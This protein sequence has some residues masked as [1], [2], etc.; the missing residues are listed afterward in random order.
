MK[1][2]K[3]YKTIQRCGYTFTVEILKNGKPGKIEKD[4]ML[5]APII[6]KAQAGAEL[7]TAE[8]LTLIR[9][10]N[11]SYHDSGKI[12]G[13]FSLDSTATNCSFCEKMRELAKINP[14]MVCAHCYDKEQESYRSSVLNRHTL[15]M[16]IMATVEF[17]V[18]ELALIPVYGLVRINSSGDAPNDIYAAN[19]VKFAIAH[20]DCRVS[21]WTKNALAYIRAC[22][23]YGKPG[24]MILIFSSYCVNKAMRLP[25]YFDYVFTVYSDADA[26]AAALAGGAC[27]CNGK[28]CADCGYKCYTGAWTA[29]AN[30]AELLR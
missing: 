5:I 3:E 19:M 8:R 28:K 6:E 11:V 17:T 24:N 15:N 29:G 30:I 22:N 9:V 21:A 18:D 23:K 13:I 16:L 1:S 12:A 20:K 25:K 14:D 26:V 4:L 10:Y 2:P 27:E 7:T